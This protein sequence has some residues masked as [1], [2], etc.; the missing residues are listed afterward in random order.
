MKKIVIG[1]LVIIITIIA[2][3]VINTNVDIE[4]V[5]AKY[6]IY[7][8]DGY[9]DNKNNIEA[10][11]YIVANK[12][13]EGYRY[14]YIN[15]KGK[16]LLKPEYN[17]VYRVMDIED[18]DKVYLIS[19]KDGRY[20]VS[21][22]GK[23]LIKYEYQFIEYSSKIEGFILQKT[24]DY[25]VANIKGKIIIP[26]ENEK[27]EVKGKYIYVS[28]QEV[29]KVYNKNGEEQEIDYN[30]TI[31][32]TEN[33]NYFIKIIEKDEHY[34]YG[35][36]DKNGNEL[37]P[38]NYTYIEYLF[39]DYFIA[40]NENMK[41]GIIN[42]NNEIKLE[43]NYNL[44]Q[45]IQNTNLIRTLNG[46]TAETEIYSQNFEKICTMKNANMEKEGNTIKVYNETETIYFDKNGIEI[47]N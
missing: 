23:E 9:Y 24:N 19:A 39:E 20:G 33:E 29:S 10:A 37:I 28:N 7:E 16:V 45:N 36:I 2:Y 11:G 8:S 1:I 5:L 38:A 4:K 17:H 42:Q 26:V 40:S 12:T 22:N 21:I 43:F 25:G 31:N 13:E 6:E 32:S 27:V 3:L 44:V 35:I 34:L 47:K 18:K 14:G 30:T 46:E 41:E 15:Y